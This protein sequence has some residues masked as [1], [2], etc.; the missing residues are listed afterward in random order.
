VEGFSAG[1]SIASKARCKQKKVFAFFFLSRLGLFFVG[2]VPCFCM[3]G[4]GFCGSVAGKEAPFLTTAMVANYAAM[5]YGVITYCIVKIAC[6]HVCMY[7]SLT[8]A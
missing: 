6:I 5:Y 1:L 8:S 7:V 4:A 3:L 2:L